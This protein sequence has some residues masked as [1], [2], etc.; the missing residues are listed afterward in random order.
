MSTEHQGLLAREEEAWSRFCWALEEQF[1]GH[2]RRLGLPDPDAEEVIQDAWVAAVRRRHELQDS[3]GPDRFNSWLWRVLRNKAIDLLRR[4][5]R[6]RL[7]SSLAEVL[8]TDEEPGSLDQDPAT[9][10][11]RREELDLVWAAVRRMGSEESNL[12]VRVFLMR[13]RDGRSPTEIAAATNLTR[14]QV[15]DRLRRMI[16]RLRRELGMNFGAGEGGV[17]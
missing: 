3:E 8:G 10:F 5:R 4:R 13:Y 16:A 14:K 12:S 11:R 1:R 9:Q 6:Q 2:L 15:W 17:A 7:D